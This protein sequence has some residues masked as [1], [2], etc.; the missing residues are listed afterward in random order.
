MTLVARYD[1]YADWYDAWNKPNAEQY[2]GEIGDL[3][4]PGEGLC[5][6]L[7]CGSGLYFDAIAATGRTVVGLD[8]SAD[9]LRV[10]RSRSRQVLRGDAAALPFADGTFSTVTT[11]WI[12]TDVDNFSA[13]LAEAARVLQPGG[14]LV[15]YGAHPCFNGPHV[16]WL[17]DGGIRV[18]PTYRLADW[19][20]PAAWWGKRVRGRV[21]MRHHPLADVLNGFVQAGLSIERVIE[22]GGQPVPIVLG[23][24]ARKL[25]T[26]HASLL[27]LGID[28]AGEILTLQ[29]AAYITEAQAHGDL[30][31]PPLTQTLDQLRAEL[32]DPQVTAWG[33]RADGR[34]VASARVRLVDPVTAEVG[35]LTVAPDRQGNGL[36]TTLLVAAEGRLPV[37]VTLV[38]L[39]TGEHS[40]ANLRLY[41]RLGYQ[42]TERTPAGPYYL[43]HLAKSRSVESQASLRAQ[44]ARNEG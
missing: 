44:T 27:R 20:E 17:D 43:V 18:H 32:A 9:Q 12:S 11:L 25:S 37:A 8:Y 22:A 26:G 21:G 38:R 3:L 33:I 5:L 31:M 14:L 40:Q 39:F 10:A 35:R 41:Q 13:V 16:E 6:D 23:I 42:E 34:L 19:H 24:R 29:R 1:G 15:F 30:T 4:G 7:G 28:D 36:G 2:A